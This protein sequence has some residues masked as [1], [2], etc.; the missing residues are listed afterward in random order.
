VHTLCRNVRRE[1]GGRRSR[2]RRGR[3]RWPGR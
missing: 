3:A 2:G 1:E